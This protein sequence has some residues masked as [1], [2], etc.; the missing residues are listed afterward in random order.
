MIV[1]FYLSFPVFLSLFLFSL[2]LSFALLPFVQTFFCF[3]F[4]Y[5]PF[6]VSSAVAMRDS[7]FTAACERFVN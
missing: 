3:F 4:F 2:S 6:T 1:R 5:F 7:V